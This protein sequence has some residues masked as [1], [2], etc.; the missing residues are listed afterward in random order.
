[1]SVTV[2][3]S[4]D[5]KKKLETLQEGARSLEGQQEVALGDLMPPEF[6]KACSE[7]ASLGDPNRTTGEC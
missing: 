2:T 4:G 7:Y 3:Q 6:I 1:M 5:W